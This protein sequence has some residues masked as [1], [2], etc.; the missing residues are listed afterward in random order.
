MQINMICADLSIMEQ[1]NWAEP[2]W[3]HLIRKN[4]SRVE[5]AQTLFF[6]E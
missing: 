1:N 6:L 5:L 3:S 2:K 4:S